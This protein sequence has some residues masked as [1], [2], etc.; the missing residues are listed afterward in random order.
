RVGDEKT[1]ECIQTP[2]NWSFNK[3]SAAI[4]TGGVGVFIAAMFRGEIDMLSLDPP[5]YIKIILLI[6]MFSCVLLIRLYVNKVK[7]RDLYQHVDLKQLKKLEIKVKPQSFKHIA[8]MFASYFFVL[9]FTILFCGAF[10]IEGN[11]I[12]LAAGA[13][14]LIMFSLLINIVIKEGL[15]EIEFKK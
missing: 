13:T 11:I 10:F 1:I 12:V 14:V 4:A 6:L 9:L 7:F 8:Q 2:E 3:R 5:L 15:T